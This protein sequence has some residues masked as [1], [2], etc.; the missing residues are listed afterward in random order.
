MNVG[1][2]NQTWFYPDKELSQSDLNHA[3]SVLQQ[4]NHIPIPDSRKNQ[5]MLQ[6]FKKLHN[7]FS[8]ENSLPDWITDL[9]SLNEFLGVQI[10][11]HENISRGNFA[12]LLEAIVDPFNRQ[13]INHYGQFVLDQ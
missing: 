8:S 12:L 9:K 6:W 1:W 11:T 3:L 5:D 10:T 7:L 2:E 13:P 4:F